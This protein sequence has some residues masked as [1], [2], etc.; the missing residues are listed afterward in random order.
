MA[1]VDARERFAKRTAKWI[2]AS[3]LPKRDIAARLTKWPLDY[4]RMVNDAARK[5]K[6]KPPAPESA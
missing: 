6:G 4:V 5:L 1:L 3:G 2:M